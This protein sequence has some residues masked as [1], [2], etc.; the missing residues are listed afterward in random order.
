MIEKF[1]L[2]QKEELKAIKERASKLHESV[3]QTYGGKPYS[4][5]LCMVAETM[6]RHIEELNNPNYEL[7]KV[8]Y[9]ASMFHDSIED[10][11]L[12][13]NDVAKI[14][15]KYMNLDDATWATEIVY[16]L[17]NEKGRTRK[18]R[19]NEKYYKGIRDTPYAPF[20][21]ICDRIANMKHS[22]EVG[23]RMFHTY[24]KELPEFLNSIY[25]ERT[26]QGILD[27]LK[28]LVSDDD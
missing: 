22:K 5:H 8:L 12:T 20:I 3:N 24:K 15:L 26:P 9:F 27:E 21:K 2:E 23:N 19:A 16:A 13:Y 14:A 17:T 25:D 6:D 28:S 18:E 11:R 4:H 10:A 1:T 7:Y